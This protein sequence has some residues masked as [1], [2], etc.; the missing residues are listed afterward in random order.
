MLWRVLLILFLGLGATWFVP[1][2]KAFAAS[3]RISFSVDGVER[4]A[5][6]IE[7]SRLRRKTRPVIIILQ[8]AGRDAPIWRRALRFQRFTDNGGIL[9]HAEPRD[10]VWALG[11]AESIAREKSYLHNLIEQVSLNALADKSR[12]YLVGVGS[13]GAIALQAACS[14]EGRFAGVASVLSSISPVALGACRPPR[15]LP[16][17]FIAGTAD[18]KV[19]IDGGAAVL[20]GYTGPL[21]PIDAV[22]S[23]FA[24]FSSCGPRRQRAEIP[25]RDRGDGS[26]VVVESFSGCKEPVRLVRIQGGEHIPPVR[27]RGAR[28]PGQ[29]R[30]LST[31]LTV[32]S[33]FRLPGG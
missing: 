7:K 32:L 27:A 30:D 6:I 19:P 5:Y 4:S 9:V 29:N 8:D 33:F 22:V 28:V 26:R 10:G 17:L 2:N 12:V 1:P 11:S 3:G 20:P 25:D 21:A 31:S 13:G 14:P 23:S 18:K 16:A 15:P 24:K